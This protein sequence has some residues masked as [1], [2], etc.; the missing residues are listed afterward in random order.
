MKQDKLYLIII[1]L[2]LINLTFVG[3]T[4]FGQKS[5]RNNPRKH[6][7]PS[8]KKMLHLS[9]SQDE[10]FRKFSRQHHAAMVELQKKHK[11]CIE[12]Y[13][14]EPNDSLLER[15]KN[16]EAKK[17]LVTNEHFND[18]KS[19]LREEQLYNYDEFKEKAV[20]YILKLKRRP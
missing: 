3:I 1:A 2:L 12:R 8:A 6:H 19:V 10:Q 16:I 7:K 20:R 4:L 13:F 15:I 14:Q 18:L 11:R 9:P 5:G 17:I